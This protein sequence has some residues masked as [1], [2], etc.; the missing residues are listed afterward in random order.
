MGIGRFGDG[1]RTLT[2]L[3]AGALAD[4]NQWPGGW[5]RATGGVQD[6]GGGLQNKTVVRLTWCCGALSTTPCVGGQLLANPL[7]IAY[8]EPIEA[9]SNSVEGLIVGRAAAARLA[10][11]ATE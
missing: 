6:G 3:L 7:Q 9:A 10:L 1:R 8:V 2:G 11:S 4:E 5:H